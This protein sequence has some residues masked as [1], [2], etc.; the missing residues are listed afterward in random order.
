MLGNFAIELIQGLH[1]FTLVFISDSLLALLYSLFVVDEIL[2]D[3]ECHNHI[4]DGF[5]PL[6]LVK[7][8]PS[9][10]DVRS[11]FVL[12]LQ[13]ER[14]LLRAEVWD[15]HLALLKAIIV[16]KTD[17][18]IQQHHYVEVALSSLLIFVIEKSVALK[19]KR[20]LFKCS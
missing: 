9:R 7:N 18:G 11:G 2:V 14:S 10:Q 17:L 13:N 6:L 12:N 3:A 1:Y 8:R 5:A 16:K 15:R 19:D 4:V 20:A